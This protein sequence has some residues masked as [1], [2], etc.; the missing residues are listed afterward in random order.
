MD[1]PD[2]FIRG[3]ANSRFV[4]AEGRASAEIFQFDD[5]NRSDGCANFGTVAITRNQIKRKRTRLQRECS[6]TNF[7]IS[8]MSDLPKSNYQT[9]RDLCKI[10]RETEDSPFYGTRSF[11]CRE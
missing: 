4:D 1:Y 11:L 10:L 7:L 2:K 3:V 9:S 8:V 5:I 6:D